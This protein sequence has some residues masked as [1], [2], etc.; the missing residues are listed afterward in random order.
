MSKLN[1]KTLTV[2]AVILMLLA[3][4]FMTTPLM[5]ASG[6]TGLAGNNRQFNG[7]NPP[8][9]QNGFPSQ[10]TSPQG[11]DY[12]G[13]IIPGQG[14]S[15]F[16]NQQ[17]AG[18]GGGLQGFGFLNGMTG[19]IVY[20][21]ALLVSLAAAVGMFLTRRWGQ[22]LGVVM[23]GIYLLISLANFIPV[24]LIGFLRGLN[25]LNLGLSI[26]HFVLATAVIV[27]ALIPAKK[28]TAPAIP[29]GTPAAGA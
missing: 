3:L 6:L 29:V 23:A 15:N 25:I 20:A 19:I 7:Q 21:L 12:S 28:V 27:F 9:G 17:F 11:Q 14:G 13:Q 10:G 1:T 16:P 22:V 26:L 2:A 5:R 18:R 8:G 24:L 4:L